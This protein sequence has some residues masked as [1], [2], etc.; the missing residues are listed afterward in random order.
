M[1]LINETMSPK[2]LYV[3][4]IYNT[5]KPVV[6]SSLTGVLLASELEEQDELICIETNQSH[7]V[8]L[9]GVLNAKGALLAYSC[10]GNWGFQPQLPPSSN[11]SFLI[12][13]K[14]ENFKWR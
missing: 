12:Q 10:R 5:T 14:K 9:E 6:F 8:L 2:I 7:K 13:S 3:S 1:V 11:G 4:D